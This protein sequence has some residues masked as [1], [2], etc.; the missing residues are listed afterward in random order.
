[1]LQTVEADEKILVTDFTYLSPPSPPTTQLPPH[2]II[3]LLP[4]EY[5]SNN[6][7]LI[8]LEDYSTQD[9]SARDNPIS[10]VTMKIS[11]TN[12]HSLQDNYSA[13]GNSDS[14]VSYPPSSAVSSETNSA[15]ASEL[16]SVVVS[17]SDLPSE[18]V[19]EPDLP[20]SPKIQRSQKQTGIQDFF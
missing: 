6:P 16:S 14:D 10:Q 13:F 20:P 19:S 4:Q 7:P 11:S 18:V 1:M 17:E 12:A 5:P 8:T 15:M 9:T 3:S 2:D